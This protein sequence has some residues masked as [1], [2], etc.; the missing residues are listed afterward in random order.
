MKKTI[1]ITILIITMLSSSV[2]GISTEFSKVSNTISQL[3]TMKVEENRVSK[4]LIKEMASGLL[5]LESAIRTSGAEVTQDIFTILDRAEGAL[6]DVPE[7]YKEVQN[8]K[9]A[10][11]KVRVS[12]GVT[13]TITEKNKDAAVELS[14][15]SNHWGKKYIDNLVARGGYQVI[16]MEHLNQTTP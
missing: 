6:S 12:F 1:I 13:Q 14:D 7:S 4:T 3:E 16:Q 8:A 15:I 10:I 9:K 11:E 2:F 5:E